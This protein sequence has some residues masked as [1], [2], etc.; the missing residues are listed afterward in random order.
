MYNLSLIFIT[1][2]YGMEEGTDNIS[3]EQLRRR[4]EQ[5]IKTQ[6]GQKKKTTAIKNTALI[7]NWK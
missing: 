4:T 3:G 1:D 6:V 2:N 5:T 7:F